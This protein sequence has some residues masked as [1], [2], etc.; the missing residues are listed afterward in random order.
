MKKI[1][2]PYIL[3][4]PDLLHRVQ[5][6]R[7]AGAQ[8]KHAPDVSYPLRAINLHVPGCEAAD[9]VN[10]AVSGSPPGKVAALPGKGRAFQPRKTASGNGGG[11][12]Y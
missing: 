9:T 11:A 10:S 4:Y 2:R 1:T 7:E 5:S 8:G 3:D 6:T 12:Y